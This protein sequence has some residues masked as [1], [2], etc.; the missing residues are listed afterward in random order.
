MSQLAPPASGVSIVN[1]L[2]D[3]DGLQSKWDNYVDHHPRGSIFHASPMIRVFAAARRHRVF[4]IAAVDADGRIVALL[5]AVRVQTLP[6]PLGAVSSRSIWYAEPLCDEDS[7]GVDA[8]GELIA[9]HDRVMRRNTLFTEVRPLYASGPERAALE[10]NGYEFFD[11]LNFVVDLTQDVKQLRA[12]LRKSCRRSI[13]NGRRH[14]FQIRELDSPAGVDA[15]YAVL[16]QTYAHAHVP[17]AHRSLFEAAFRDLYPAGLLRCYAAYD[18]ERPV[19][20]DTLL[21]FKDRLFAWYGGS[22]RMTGISPFDFLQWHEL[23]WGSAQPQSIFDF[24]G[25]GRPD[26]PYGVRDFKAKFGGELVN[27]GRYRKVHAPWTMAAAERVYRVG[28]SIISPK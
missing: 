14:G 21:A 16:K 28:R 10:R 13:E 9:E 17:L 20:I 12:K 11:Y 1:L 22:V 8:L 5:A 27:F 2:E 19:A 4:A 7:A 26:E 18:G 25:A 6:D 15:L 3:W 23:E 24:G